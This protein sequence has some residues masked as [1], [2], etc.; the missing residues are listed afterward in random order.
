MSGCL[1]LI[2]RNLWGPRTP[3]WRE[4]Q[5]GFLPGYK[6]QQNKSERNCPDESFRSA[7]IAVGVS[8]KTL[9]RFLPRGLLQ[10][11]EVLNYTLDDDDDDS[12]RRFQRPLA[13]LKKFATAKVVVT[14]HL[15]VALPCVAFGTPVVFLQD[16]LSS[17]S[18]RSAATSAAV[19]GF[20][21]SSDSSHSGL[22]ELF[23]SF[24][25]PKLLSAFNW[26]SPGPNPGRALL[27]GYRETLLKLILRAVPELRF[28]RRL[29]GLVPRGPARRSRPAVLGVK[30][31][32]EAGAPVA[33]ERIF[34]ARNT[35]SLLPPADDTADEGEE[36]VTTPAPVTSIGEEEVLLD[37]APVKKQ[38]PFEPRAHMLLTRG[39]LSFRNLFP[40]AAIESWCKNHPWA[41][42][43]LWIV[44]HAV[45]VDSHVLEL[46]KEQN[47]V[48]EIFNFDLDN[49]LVGTPLEIF[50]TPQISTITRGKV[51]TRAELERGKYWYSHLTDFFRLAALWKYGGWFLDHDI[52]FLRS[53]QAWTNAVTENAPNQNALKNQRS[54]R[55]ALLNNA[56][57]HF[58]SFHPF[59]W[60]CMEDPTARS[61]RKS[62]L[63][64]N[65][66][67][68]WPVGRCVEGGGGGGVVEVRVD[69][70]VEGGT[71]EGGWSRSGGGGGGMGV[72]PGG[73]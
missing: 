58:D 50:L 43:W 61:V 26:T 12:W 67:C 1:T 36:F 7:Y 3:E 20:K 69:G 53:V 2:F 71:K 40:I 49:V 9:R 11:F 46:L 51:K 55:V 73:G 31:S 6:N 44:P 70:G 30:T 65:F 23:H 29:Y 72:G 19:L 14:N 24:A 41:P 13:Y 54:G 42:I 66:L 16:S 63:K 62:C 4:A 52:I 28:T 34:P 33:V 47:C 22:L 32:S 57:S 64:N 17:S 68:S 27:R 21:G 45:I 10:K 56:L 25:N 59:L 35:P 8:R 5:D 38:L 60:R 15:G 39:S 48:V 37:L 18:S